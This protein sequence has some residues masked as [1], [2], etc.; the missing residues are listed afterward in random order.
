MRSCRIA[1]TPPPR[2]AKARRDLHDDE[3]MLDIEAG[4][5]LIEKEKARLAIQNRLPDLAE[6]RGQVEHA[7][8]HRRKAP[9]RSG[10]RIRQGRPVPR[11]S[12]GRCSTSYVVPSERPLVSPSLTIS[13]TV[14]GN[15]SDGR[16]RQ[17]RRRIAAICHSFQ[18]AQRMP[19][20]GGCP[21]DRADRPRA[22][23]SAWSC[24]NRSGPT[25]TVISPAKAS[26][27]ALLHDLGLAQM[28]RR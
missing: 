6:I 10:R 14:N 25:M 19:V 8:V 21:A 22:R 18:M 13:R 9:G 28:T 12:S 23:A 2:L 11:A 17:D 5:G 16:L 7:A 3:L 1:I 27:L 20:D 26:K 15:A 24:P 4:D